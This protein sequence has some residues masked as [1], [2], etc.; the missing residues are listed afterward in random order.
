M[1]LTF[2]SLSLS[3]RCKMQCIFL[4]RRAITQYFF[5]C[6]SFLLVHFSPIVELQQQLSSLLSFLHSFILSF[7]LII[8]SRAHSSFPNHFYSFSIISLAGKM[9]FGRVRVCV[10]W[11]WVCECI[12]A[13]KQATP[14]IK[15][16]NKIKFKPVCAQFCDAQCRKERRKIAAAQCNT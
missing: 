2:L 8:S 13:S 10:S 12:C 3:L 7:F 5:Y 9:T 1:F 4:P 15:Q 6:L 16:K 14:T 11:S